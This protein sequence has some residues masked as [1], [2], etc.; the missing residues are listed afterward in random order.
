M[1]LA[2]RRRLETSRL[3]RFKYGLRRD[4]EGF[5]LGIRSPPRYVMP[6]N[7]CP[8]RLIAIDEVMLKMASDPSNT[9]GGHAPQASIDPKDRRKSPRYPIIA[10]ARFIDLGLRNLRLRTEGSASARVK[11]P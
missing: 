1:C 2:E 6:R 10:E 5:G 8:S 4:R 3:V 11:F 9:Y 7:L